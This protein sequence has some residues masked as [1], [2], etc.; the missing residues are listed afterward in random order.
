MEAPV[1]PYLL[2]CQLV[3]YATRRGVDAVIVSDT[4]HIAIAGANG[5]TWIPCRRLSD[6]V[7]IAGGA[8]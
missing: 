5:V 1:L 7:A 2:A 8:E 6:V 4:C 3:A